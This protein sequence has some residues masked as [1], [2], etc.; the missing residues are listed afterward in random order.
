MNAQI[1][2]VLQRMRLA[3]LAKLPQKL[4]DME[5]LVHELGQADDCTDSF[6]NLYRAVHTLKGT[7]GTYGLQIITAICTPFEDCLTAAHESDMSGSDH[8]TGYCMQFIGILRD[9]ITRLEA[10]DESFME[11]E[12]CLD[13]FNWSVTDSPMKS[14]AS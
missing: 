13:E 3:Y 4:D 5:T 8:V 6:E 10:G 2:E 7:A 14:H 9:A 12:A 11:I 1:H